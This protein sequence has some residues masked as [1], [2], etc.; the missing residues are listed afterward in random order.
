MAETVHTSTEAH[1]GAKAQGGVFPPF[2]SS[3]FASQL[4]WLALAFGVFYWVMARKVMPLIGGVI[5]S[6]RDSIDRDLVEA[7]RLKGESNAASAAYELS[8]SEAGKKAGIIAGETRLQLNAS[9]D[10]KRQ[11]A[12]AALSGSLAEAEA[13]IGE[14][15]ARAM[16]EVGGI[17]RE[18]ADV[19][20]SALSGRTASPNEI[21]TAVDAA[22][23]K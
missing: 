14:I 23:Q 2:D 18:T 10:A 19:I 12:E 13:R 3:T 15:K 7:Q 16:A 8:L 4:L 5:E 21:S 20:V 11:A 17:A 6:R 1:G 22:L 9:V